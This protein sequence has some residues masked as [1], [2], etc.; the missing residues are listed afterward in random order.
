MTMESVDLLRRLAKTALQ[1][2]VWPT[3]RLRAEVHASPGLAL[4]LLVVL[5][6]CAGRAIM[7]HRVAALALI[8]LSVAW[9]LF[10]GPFEGP[11]LVTLSWAHGITASDLISVVCLGI[12]AWR[13]LPRLAGT[14]TR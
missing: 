5:L 14:L 11:T 3:Q 4:L 2:L 12:S 10:N 9:V 1:P 8:P 13:L 7:G 6:V